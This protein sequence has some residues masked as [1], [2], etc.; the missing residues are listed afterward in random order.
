MVHRSVAEEQPMRNVH[1]Q[2]HCC[3][4]RVRSDR[5]FNIGYSGPEIH[6]RVSS[7]QE[8]GRVSVL[9]NVQPWRPGTEHLKTGTQRG[10]QCRHSCI[11]FVIPRLKWSGQLQQ[12]VACVG[13]KLQFGFEFRDGSSQGPLI[14]VCSGL[15]V[16]ELVSG[17]LTQ[18]VQQQSALIGRALPGDN[19]WGTL[20]TVLQSHVTDKA[21]LS[22]VDNVHQ[23]IRG[24]QACWEVQTILRHQRSSLQYCIHSLQLL[25][26]VPV[27]TVSNCSKRI[28]LPFYPVCNCLLLNQGLLFCTRALAPNVRQHAFKNT[29]ITG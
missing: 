19:F 21:I 22:T 14:G 13:N 1:S 23:K 4:Y 16:L 18:Y 28:L 29:F 6:C 7:E 25:R 10:L 11:G 2:T 9:T 12:G 15:G 5:R 17:C 24:H 27:Q 8:H 20:I 26:G 3:G